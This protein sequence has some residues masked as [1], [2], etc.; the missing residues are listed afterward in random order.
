MALKINPDEC[1]MCGD[2]EPVCPTK[3]I[4][5]GKMTF[6]IDAASCTECEGT[7]DSPKCM[8]TCP[9]GAIVYA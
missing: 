6:K 4:S 7:S 8:D 1:T 3:S 9:A 2:C 5:E